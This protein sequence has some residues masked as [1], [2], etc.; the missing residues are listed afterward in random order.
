MKKQLTSMQKYHEA[1]ISSALA[2]LV[3][4]E[5]QPINNDVLTSVEY[6]DAYLKQIKLALSYVEVVPEPKPISKKEKP[7]R[8]KS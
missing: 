5:D 4:G 2:T 6:H 7:P 3:E 8:K 1:K